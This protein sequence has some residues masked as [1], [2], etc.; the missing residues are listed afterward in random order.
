MID[1]LNVNMDY[2]PPYIKDIL[3]RTDIDTLDTLEEVYERFKYIIEKYEMIATD[4]MIN[5]KR[6]KDENTIQF[7]FR[8][9]YIGNKLVEKENSD[10][11]YETKD[12]QKCTDTFNTIIPAN[13]R[14]NWPVQQVLIIMR[15]MYILK[16]NE[17]IL[18]KTK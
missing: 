9:K 5:I 17:Q 2:S 6:N 11:V 7:G 13:D 14:Y 15:D 8:Y 1:K 16:L 3:F 10:G 4:H 18:N 12:N